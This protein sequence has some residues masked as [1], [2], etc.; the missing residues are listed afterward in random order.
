MQDS[1]N[2]PLLSFL[3]SSLLL[4]AELE[5]AAAGENIPLH[6]RIR[7]LE[8]LQRTNKESRQARI[9]PE[10]I[11]EVIDYIQTRVAA[12]QDLAQLA[13]A[14]R[15]LQQ[16]SLS[17]HPLLE[18]AEMYRDSLKPTCDKIRSDG[19]KKQA[20]LDSASWLAHYDLLTN[21]NT[22]SG[23]VHDVD[24]LK[25][26]LGS[27]AKIDRLP[28][29]NSLEALR[30]LQDAWDH[31]EVYQMAATSYKHIAKVTYLLMLI[32]GILITAFSLGECQFGFSSRIGVMVVGV[33]A[34]AVAAYVTFTNPATRWQQLRTAALSIESNIWTF[35]TRSGPYRTS[36]E[37]FDQIADKVL[38]EAVQEMK[39]SVLEG[40]DLKATSFFSRAS[41][42]NLHGQ[43]ASVK[44]GFGTSETYTTELTRSPRS[45][46]IFSWGH[47]FSRRKTKVTPAHLESSSTIASNFSC[48]IRLHL[49][50]NDG[51]LKLEEL[52]AW[53]RQ[54]DNT[55]A[56]LRQVDSHYTPVQPDLY[57]RFRVTKALEFYKGRIPHCHRT[58]NC[59][60]AFLVLGSIG[61]VVLAF[62]DK[63]VWASAISILTTGVTALLE[64]QGTNSKITRYSST[65]HALQKV[66]LWW[67]ALPQIDRS[68]VVNIDRLVLTCEELLQREQQAWRSTSQAVKFLEK[69]VVSY[70]S[71]S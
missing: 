49:E 38:S 17:G 29:A 13:K 21:P 43:H 48:R 41:S 47:C 11:A 10:L 40:A 68:V 15:W 70:Q 57:I 23:S 9:P 58:R 22:F 7:D 39:D 12:L 35:R 16:H 4:G 3:H 19:G 8:K 50:K 71:R 59:A 45:P 14:E 2:C 37:G 1:L 56:E 27:V 34:T 30:T 65:V 54:H 55:E 31:V 32:C 53:L 61:A 66:I 5:G 63:S 25:R 36:G 6:I 60:Q 46:G 28:V 33:F 52:V 62:F 42:Q 26:I 20:Q 44:A 64:F 24:G 18:E 69:Q 51:E 67:Q